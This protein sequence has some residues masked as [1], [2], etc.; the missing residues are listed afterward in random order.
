[1]PPDIRN[2]HAISALLFMVAVNEAMQVFGTFCS[3]PQ[4][5]ELFAKVREATLMKWVV[6]A[7]VNAIAI[8]GFASLLA[9][10]LWPLIGGL[11]VIAELHWLYKHAARVGKR[12]AAPAG[13]SP[14]AAAP[15]SRPR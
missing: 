6:V 12:A 1:M 15:S 11:L 13:H 9:R 14:A 7:N 5:T 4:T 2:R 8:S 3:S 10:S